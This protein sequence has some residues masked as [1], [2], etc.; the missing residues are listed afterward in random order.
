MNMAR[1]LENS[2]PIRWLAVL[3]FP[4]SFEWSDR[5]VA[6]FPVISA[7]NRNPPR[8]QLEED[9]VL[10]NKPMQA[11]FE[12]QAL[13]RI[14]IFKHISGTTGSSVIFTVRY[15]TLSVAQISDPRGRSLCSLFT[16]KSS[17]HESFDHRNGC[18][19]LNAVVELRKDVIYA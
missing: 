14:A 2:F 5:R 3:N 7:W 16:E 8:R 9:D 15:T 18:H 13:E 11:T 17:S 19:Q 1:W 6:M 12:L 10:T 4:K